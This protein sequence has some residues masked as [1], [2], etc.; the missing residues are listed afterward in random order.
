MEPSLTHFLMNVDRGST[1]AINTGEPGT[2]PGAEDDK[3]WTETNESDNTNNSVTF[4][5]SRMIRSVFILEEGALVQNAVCE[6]GF[7]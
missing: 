6:R 4:N 5:G 1:Q 7:I 3:S 2:H